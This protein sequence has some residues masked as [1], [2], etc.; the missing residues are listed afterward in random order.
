M[1][2]PMRNVHC[3]KNAPEGRDSV[4]DSIVRQLQ[5][6]MERNARMVARLRKLAASGLFV[7]GD[8]ALTY[9]HSIMKDEEPTW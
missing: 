8:L 6:S 1:S 2:C 3:P 9:L 4:E 7:S 5:R